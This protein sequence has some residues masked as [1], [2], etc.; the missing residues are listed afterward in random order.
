MKKND[1]L[2]SDIQNLCKAVPDLLIKLLTKNVMTESAIQNKTTN[3]GSRG[4]EVYLRS[5]PAETFKKSQP[6]FF[7]FSDQRYLLNASRN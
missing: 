7:H 6:T 2:F 5:I 4:L 1:C 3:G